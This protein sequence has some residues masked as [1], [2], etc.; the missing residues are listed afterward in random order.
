V[1]RNA[2]APGDFTSEMSIADSAI[3]E[4]DTAR[5]LFGQEIVAATVGAA[6]PSPLVAESLQDPLLVLLEMADGAVVDVEVFANCQYGYDVRCEVVGSHGSASLDVPRAASVMRDGQ[7]IQALPADWRARF[8][9]A[10]LE[11]LQQWVTGVS[12][13]NVGGPSAWDGYAANAVAEQCV[14]SLRRGGRVEIT[15]IDRPALYD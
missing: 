9:S 8:D 7:R 1:H 4:I 14:V 6:R 11:E 3:H 5:W 12:R 2:A 10:Y 13:G 15:L